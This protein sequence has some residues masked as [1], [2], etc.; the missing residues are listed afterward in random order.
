VY[1]SVLA[2]LTRRELVG[3]NGPFARTVKTEAAAR[4]QLL[5]EARVAPQDQT[6]DIFLSPGVRHAREVLAIKGL[7]MQMGYSVYADWVEDPE[8]DRLHVTARTAARLRHRITAS[9]SLLVHATEGARL[10]RRLPWELGFADGL[11]RPVG[12]LPVVAKHRQVLTYKGT[13]YL[14]LYPYID[15]APA[16]EGEVKPWANLNSKTYVTFRSWLKGKA[17][18]RRVP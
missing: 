11:R 9:R 8:M 2:L 10:S 4:S 16:D 1:R 5:S 6:F 15:F 14:G 7:F 13:E 17:P 3:P 12:I 18:Y